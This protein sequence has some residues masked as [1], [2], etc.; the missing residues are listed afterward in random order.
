VR[1]GVPLQ[2][3]SHISAAGPLGTIVG[4]VQVGVAVQRPG[5]L[6]PDA[7]VG[8]LGVPYAADV[9]GTFEDNDVVPLT[10]E[11]VRGGKTGH[12]RANDADA[13]L[14]SGRRLFYCQWVA[15][16]SEHLVLL[17]CIDVV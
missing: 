5:R 9:V 13:F 10:A 14:T 6:L 8:P 3:P 1:F 7:W 12:S 4:I 17:V 2:V 16:L 11:G 15:V